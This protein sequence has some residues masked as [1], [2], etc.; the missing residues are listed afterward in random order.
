[1][2]PFAVVVHGYYEDM[3]GCFV[4]NFTLLPSMTLLVSISL[5]VLA[6]G[7]VSSSDMDSSSLLVF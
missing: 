5:L 1:M 3:L 4:A 6:M 7:S 2:V